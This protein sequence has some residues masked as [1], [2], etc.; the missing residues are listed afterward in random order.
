MHG[1]QIRNGSV[2]I[3]YDSQLRETVNKAFHHQCEFQAARWD[4]RNSRAQTLAETR[5]RRLDQQ[6]PCPIGETTPLRVLSNLAQ[7]EDG[8]E[9]DRP[10]K[11]ALNNCRTLT[12]GL[13]RWSISRRLVG[14]AGWRKMAIRE[15]VRP[16][17][18]I[19]VMID[20]SSVD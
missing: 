13:D 12:P 17:D 11:Q 2:K 8:V 14:A 18:I 6:P 7:G 9:E 10:G 5:F 20:G 1:D 19:I 3:G 15:F 4:S 16:S